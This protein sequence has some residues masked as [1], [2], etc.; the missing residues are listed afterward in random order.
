MDFFD[1]RNY[2]I[3]KI[4]L[5]IIGQWPY[6]SSRMNHTVVFILAIISCSQFLTKLCGMFPYIYDMD[7][8][9]ECLIPIIIDISSITKVMNSM[10][11]MNEIRILLDRIRDDFV[12]LRD[13][14]D[15]NVL[16]KYAANGRKLSTIYICMLYIL[17]VIFVLMPLQPLIFRDANVTTR[18]LLHKVEYFID[19]DKYYLLILIHGYVTVVICITSIV[20]IDTTFIIFVQHA[21]GL[22]I[23]TS[24]RIKRAIQRRGHSE[25]ADPPIIQDKTYQNMVQ[26]VC[27][28]IAAVRFADLME[29]VYSKQFLFHAGLNTIIISIAGVAVTTNTGDKSKL[30]RTIAVSWASL[31]HLCFECLNTQRLINYSGY[32]YS[33]LMNLNWY[34]ASLRTKKL[35]PFMMMRMQPPCV[36]TA[37]G[38]FV[39]CMETFTTILKTALS[40]FTFLHGVSA[41]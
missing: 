27:D 4:L 29:L 34:D 6:Q 37:G 9:I 13:S 20:A 40:Y 33:N 28:H 19:M 31:F 38:M 22:F 7:I 30:F 16:R 41:R 10:F 5:S 14:S 15:I 24:L 25:D 32:L 11:Y 39:L 3:S 12:S 23:V 8:L 2:R 35:I 1:S 36:L 17:T 18:P 21:C 26:C